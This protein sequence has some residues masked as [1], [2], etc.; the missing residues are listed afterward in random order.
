MGGAVRGVAV[1]VAAR[2]AALGTAGEV[3]VT[4]TVRDL[5]LGSGRTLVPHGEHTFAGVPGTWEVLAV[6]VAHP[7]TP[8]RRT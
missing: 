2:V 1:H 3:L 7:P 6:D 4:G 5:V 8:E